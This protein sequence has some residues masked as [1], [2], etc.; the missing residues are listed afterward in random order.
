MSAVAAVPGGLDLYEFSDIALRHQLW[1]S[2]TVTS[3]ATRQLLLAPDVVLLLNGPA[4]LVLVVKEFPRELHFV[5]PAGRLVRHV[6]DFFFRTQV[7]RRIAMAI[8]APFH[9]Q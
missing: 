8:Q 9:L 5:V 3:L 2:L 4:Q 1:S 6:E 7:L